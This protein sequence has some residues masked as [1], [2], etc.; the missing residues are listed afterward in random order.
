MVFPN[1]F[2][3]LIEKH[4]QWNPIFS[5]VESLGLQL[6]YEQDP[7]HTFSHEFIFL[8]EKLFYRKLVDSCFYNS[9]SYVNRHHWV[10]C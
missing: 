7:L 1:K 5:H 4:F 9:D 3:I 10:N 6:Y 2:A 8:S